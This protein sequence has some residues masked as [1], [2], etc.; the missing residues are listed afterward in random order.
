LASTT[1]VRLILVGMMGSGKTTVGRLLAEATGWPYVDNDELLAAQTGRTAS[2]IAAGGETALRAAE[3]DAL[4]AGLATPEPCIVGAAAG[5]ILDPADR[6]AIAEAGTVVWLR[7]RPETL[8][9]RALGAS[10]RPWLGADPL[11]W[12]QAGARE[13]PALYA[14]VADVIVDVDDLEPAQVADEILTQARIPISRT[15]TTHNSA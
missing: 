5:T 12:F 14:S 4:L 11:A 3:S 2:E 9:R 8:A 7:A 6:A 15:D 1:A 13:R 10:H